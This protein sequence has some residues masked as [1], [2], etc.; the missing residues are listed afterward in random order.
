MATIRN[1]ETSRM[2]RFMT[3]GLSGTLVDFAALALLKEVV[4]LPT[5]LANTLSFS[6]GLV[7]NFTWNRLWT[8]ADARNDNITRQFIQFASVSLVGLLMNNLILLLLE[9]PLD[10]IIGNYGYIP[11][12]IIATGLV[13]VWNFTANR[14]WT[15]HVRVS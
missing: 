3:V 6:A 4:L 10:A 13:F 5:L 11:A 7:N 12:K 1:P 15:F 8:F 14:Y 9:N 2:L